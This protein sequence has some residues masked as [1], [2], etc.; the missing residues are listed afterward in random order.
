MTPPGSIQTSYEAEKPTELHKA[1]C[2]ERQKLDV[3]T[4]QTGLGGGRPPLS[5]HARFCMGTH[6]RVPTCES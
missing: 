3:G 2:C 5:L 6:V 4:E 1:H